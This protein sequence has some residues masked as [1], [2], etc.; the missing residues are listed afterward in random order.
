M[1]SSPEPRPILVTCPKGLP[2]FLRAELEALGLPARELTSGVQTQGDMRTAM[3]LNLAL[4]TGHRVLL[5]LARFQARDPVELGRELFRLPWEDIVPV[6][7]HLTVDSSVQ[8]DHVRDGRFAN[9]KAKDAI[10]DRILEQEGRRPDSGPDP[11][12]ACV[13]LHWRGADVTVYLDTTG[14]PLSRRGYRKMPHTAPLQETLAAGVVLATGWSGE[15]HF[16]SPMC[17]SG[18]LGIEAALLA[19][20]R[21]P[22]LLRS[23]F[24]FQHLIGYDAED[25]ELLRREAHAQSRKHLSGRILLSDADPAA[26]EAARQNARTA[27]VDTHLEFAVCDFREA[28]VPEGP[29]V[30]VLN[31]EY[32]ER[33]GDEQHLGATYSGIGDFFKQRLSGWRAYVFTGNAELAKQV[34]LRPKRRIP[35]FNAKIECRLLE[36]EMY[37][38][39]RRPS[40][41]EAAATPAP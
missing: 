37:Q 38:G 39:T 4:R 41:G 24:A 10:V 5:E 3:R 36:Y 15:G 1:Q 20:N 22:G 7:G 31:P 23:G 35:F 19:L 18:T 8:N 27:G 34:G 9:Q 11:V 32:G 21:A 6:D 12:G 30:C 16:L 26:V 14:A 17:G 28:E 2:P 40:G 29:G 25:F 33:M 13:F